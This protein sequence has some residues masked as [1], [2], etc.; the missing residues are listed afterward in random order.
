MRLGPKLPQSNG[1]VWQQSHSYKPG[2]TVD[3]LF[4]TAQPMTPKLSNFE[5]E[6]LLS[7]SLWVR[8]PGVA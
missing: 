7:Q 2:K 6:T 5:Q 8:N 1:F 4:M 3:L